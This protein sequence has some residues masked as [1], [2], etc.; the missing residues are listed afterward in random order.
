MVSDLSQIN[1]SA[2]HSC[3]IYFWFDF[4]GYKNF[5]AFQTNI[6]P[7]FFLEIP[8][9]CKVNCPENHNSLCFA[10]IWMCDFGKT[11]QKETKIKTNQKGPDLKLHFFSKVNQWRNDVDDD[12]LFFR[13]VVQKKYVELYFQLESLAE[14]I[15]IANLWQAANRTWTCSE[16]EF[17]TSWMN[18]CNEFVQIY[19]LN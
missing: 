9:F 18:L 3:W 8:G 2:N 5:L 7:L 10:L 1:I 16:P 17:R 15:I 14:V 4:L 12:G 6:I 11:K 19:S 13:M